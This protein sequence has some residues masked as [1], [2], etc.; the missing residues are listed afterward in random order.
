ML[1][2]LCACPRSHRP[3][4]SAI[5]DLNP[6]TLMADEGSASPTPPTCNVWRN[7]KTDPKSV[8]SLCPHPGFVQ[9]GVWVTKVR[10]NR[11]IR[12][13][14]Y[15]RHV[16]RCSA[17]SC[18]CYCEVFFHN[19]FN[20]SMGGLETLC[21]ALGGV[22]YINIYF[23]FFA[24]HSI[25]IS[26]PWNIHV[27]VSAYLYFIT[28]FNVRGILLETWCWLLGQSF[29]VCF[30]VY[31]SKVLFIFNF[32]FFFCCY[33]FNVLKYGPSPL[34]LFYCVHGRKL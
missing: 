14:V 25:L 8:S 3:F 13:D 26:P 21:V 29:F 6:F 27:S 11:W 31:I 1:S 12:N 28:F 32:F 7:Y 23:I 15:L 17:R 2:A 22:G 5:C 19:W 16:S 10:K 34:P 30:F 4:S 9:A 33:S 24:H 18:A 20:W